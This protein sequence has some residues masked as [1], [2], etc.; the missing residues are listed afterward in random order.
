MDV[1]CSWLCCKSTQFMFPSYFIT[2]FFILSFSKNHKSLALKSKEY[3]KAYDILL[4]SLVPA[5]IS[6]FF[7]FV[8]PLTIQSIS[9][10]S[11]LI[12]FI[13]SLLIHCYERW[14]FNSL[15]SP[16]PMDGSFIVLA[17]WFAGI[18]SLFISTVASHLPVLPPSF[19]YFIFIQYIFA[20]VLSSLASFTFSST[21][22][23]SS[24]HSS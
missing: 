4:P 23:V 21:R 9:I 14:G 3:L 8:N 2:T 19:L 17:L 10:I 11:W 22:I 5:L 12:N 7:S 18:I 16:L 13:W 15:Y 20:F 24:T 1:L 6:I